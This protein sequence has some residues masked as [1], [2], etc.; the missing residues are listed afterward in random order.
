MSIQ[1]YY[2]AMREA[3]ERSC[4]WVKLGVLQSLVFAP[5]GPVDPVQRDKIE[6]QYVNEEVRRTGVWLIVLASRVTIYLYH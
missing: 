1:G 2:E 4:V 6:L 3:V 5:V